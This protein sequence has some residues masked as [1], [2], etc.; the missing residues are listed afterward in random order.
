MSD[1]TKKCPYCAEAILADARKCKHCGEMLDAKPL[2]IEQTGKQYK[3]E[4]LLGA[5]IAIAGVLVA[6]FSIPFESSTAMM[7]GILMVPLGLLVFIAARARAWW[8]HG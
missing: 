5:G 7:V 1:P 4:M 3:K 6:I 2:V 8:H